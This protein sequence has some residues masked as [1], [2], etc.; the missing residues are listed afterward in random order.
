MDSCASGP[1]GSLRF[2]SPSVRILGMACTRPTISALRVSSKGGGWVRLTNSER[3]RLV[4]I[5]P[6]IALPP[7]HVIQFPAGPGDGG[8]DQQVVHRFR[9]RTVADV[10]QFLPAIFEGCQFIAVLCDRGG[11]PV[12]R[13]SLGAIKPG[14]IVKRERLLRGPPLPKIGREPLQGIRCLACNRCR[15]ATVDGTNNIR[16]NGIIFIAGGRFIGSSYLYSLSAASSGG[17]QRL[18]HNPSFAPSELARVHFLPRACAWRCL[19]ESLQRLL[20][21]RIHFARVLLRFHRG[22]GIAWSAQSL[23]LPS[24]K[25]PD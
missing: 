3:Q 15:C 10:P 4:Q 16:N 13:P 1:A 25:P 8:A 20:R 21:V 22:Q 9:A 5:E 6:G 19:H 14:D 18:C 2:A 23:R 24:Q 7:A 11:R 17:F 12:C